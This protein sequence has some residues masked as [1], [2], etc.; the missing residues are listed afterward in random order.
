RMTII[1]ENTEDAY[2]Q[3]G[4]RTGVGTPQEVA[5]VPMRF[6]R[7]G[8]ER[9]IHYAF[10]L[11]VKNGQKH[12]TLVDK[13]NAI[14]I[15]EIWRDVFEEVGKK[16]ADVRRDAM[17]VDAAAM[18]MVLKPEQ[19]DVVVTTNLFGDILSDLGAALAGGLGTASSGNINPGKVSVFEP[20]H[21]SAPKYAGKGV[22]SPSAAIGALLVLSAPTSS[23]LATTAADPVSGPTIIPSVHNDVS[24]ALT[25]MADIGD[26]DKKDTKV[27]PHREIPGHAH[28]GQSATQPAA[29]VVAA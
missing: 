18:W 26:S 28:G 7:P 14:P 2:T 10:E 9:I 1:R 25:A 15:Q 19:F 21:G 11:A 12:V 23:S 6:T 27:K 29:A 20:I 24:V 17:Y 8:V 16:F 3:E 22:A 5:S 13:A 4:Q